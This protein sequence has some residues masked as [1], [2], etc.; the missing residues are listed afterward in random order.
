MSW[1]MTEMLSTEQI[2]A[3]V[4]L[5]VHTHTEIHTLNIH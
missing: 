4:P 2:L 5:F 1:V 3:Y